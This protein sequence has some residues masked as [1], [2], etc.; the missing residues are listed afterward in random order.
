MRF[1]G[2][3]IGRPQRVAAALLLILLAEC[4]WTI[5]HQPLDADDYRYARCGREMW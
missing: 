4:L 1:K 3:Y 2:F 5:R